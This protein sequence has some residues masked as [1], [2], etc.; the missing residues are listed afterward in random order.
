[1]KCMS[2]KLVI[3]HPPRGLKGVAPIV[4]LY[5]RCCYGYYMHWEYIPSMKIGVIKIGSCQSVTVCS[6]TEQI[7]KGVYR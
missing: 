2:T 7:K 3:M 6:R 5:C 4:H 1:M